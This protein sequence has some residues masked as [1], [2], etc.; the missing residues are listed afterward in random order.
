MN[1]D[2]T[3]LRVLVTAGAQGIGLAIAEA[4]VAG[5]AQVHICDL[6]AQALACVRQRH[7]TITTSHTN[8]ADAEAVDTLFDHIDAR[9]GGQLDVL[10]NNAGIAMNKPA[11]ELSPSEWRR[12]IDIDLSGIFY[13]AQAAGKRMVKQGGG[14]ILSTASLWGLSTAAR[15]VAYCAAKAGVVSLSKC[16]AAEWA[17]YGIRVNAIAPGEIETSILSPGT[18][19]LV[20]KLPLRRL[21]STHE[22]ADTIFYLCSDG[23]SY[24]TGAQIHINGGQHV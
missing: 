17:Q 15:R 20:E 18:E 2:V 4:F 23:A 6:N 12:A 10:V 7:P 21:G 9:W 11:L 14:V 1:T 3:G 24:V 19:K 16:L 13:C 8:V 5:G 22:V